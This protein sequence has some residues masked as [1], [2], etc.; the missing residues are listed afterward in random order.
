[1]FRSKSAS[2]NASRMNLSK[3]DESVSEG[4]MDTSPALCSNLHF[5]H[6][7]CADEDFKSINESSVNRSLSAKNKLKILNK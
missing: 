6:M 2:R 1:M 5:S 3:M 7:H 4:K